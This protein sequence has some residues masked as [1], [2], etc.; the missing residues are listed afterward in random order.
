MEVSQAAFEF[1]VEKMSQA[2][3]RM[4]IIIIILIV[5]LVGTNIAWILYES[6]Y[7]TETYQVQSD[8][9]NANYIGNDGDIHNGSECYGE[10]EEES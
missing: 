6:Q 7:E 2:M 3:K 8:D 10:K 5:A 9:G 4:L 1:T